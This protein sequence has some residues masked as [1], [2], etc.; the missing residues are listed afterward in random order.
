MT[1][2]SLSIRETIRTQGFFLFKSVIDPSL[3]EHAR[4]K[5][6]ESVAAHADRL[7]ALAE[8]GDLPYCI[9]MPVNDHAPL[10]DHAEE[11]LKSIG[12][13]PY[14]LTNLMLIMKNPH[15]GR[16]FWHTDSPAIFA[17][18]EEDAPELFVLYFLQ[19]TTKEN[20]ALLVVP[21]YAEG[22]QHSERVATP[23]EGEHAIETEPGDVI[24][25]DPRL[26]HGSLA[27][28][29]DEH[30]FNVRLWIQTRWKEKDKC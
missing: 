21:G 7:K 28:N 22:P 29:T 11:L 15:E 23:I 26:L 14:W 2:T 25:F 10:L 19:K 3:L 16:R 6:W 20:G 1:P 4:V 9:P 30:R 12:A 18:S 8:A 27:N 13:D 24:V 17:P 5:A